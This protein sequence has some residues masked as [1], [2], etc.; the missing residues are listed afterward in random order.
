MYSQGGA[1]HLAALGCCL[2]GRGPRGNDATCS[3]LCWLSVTSPAT[4]N[5]IGPFWCCFLSGWVCVRSRPLWV[6]PTTSPVRLGVSVLPPQPPR[7]FSIR[8]LRLYFP[9]LEP[10]VA[11]FALL[12][13]FLPV[14]LCENVG[15]QGPP[16]TTFPG[17]LSAPPSCL[18]ECFFF[19]SL[20]VGLP[21]HSIF[22]QF[23]LF[24][25]LKFLLSFFR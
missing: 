20:V 17:V 2:W 19:I 21:Y 16:A 11:Q 3:A 23:W 15:S 22:C 5:Q 4:H 18:D 9:A 10:W 12:P 24:F 13:P 7:V 14:Y 6:S 1:T 8:G 25:V